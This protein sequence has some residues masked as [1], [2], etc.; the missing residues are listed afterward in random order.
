M[1]KNS[2]KKVNSTMKICSFTM[3]SFVPLFLLP[4]F[5]FLNIKTE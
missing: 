5:R 2:L 3:L 1:R 4:L